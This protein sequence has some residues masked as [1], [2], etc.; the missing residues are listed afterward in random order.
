LVKDWCIGLIFTTNE[1]DYKQVK[2]WCG[3]YKQ[4]GFF[5]SLFNFITGEVNYKPN[6]GLALQFEISFLQHNYQ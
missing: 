2:D 5:F 4:F 1:V 3:S 6:E